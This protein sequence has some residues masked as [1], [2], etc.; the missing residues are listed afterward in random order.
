MP[1]QL[2]VGC[3]ANQI[4]ILIKLRGDCRR[5]QGAAIQGNCLNQCKCIVVSIALHSDF[6]PV[7]FEPKQV[8][9]PRDPSPWRHWEKEERSCRQRCSS[10]ADG[11]GDLDHVHQL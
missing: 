10:Q 6:H 2:F 8:S 9:F 7:S 11:E 1:A 4:W 5:R 3:T